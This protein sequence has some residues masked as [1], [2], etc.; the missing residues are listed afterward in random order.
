MAVAQ[1]IKQEVSYSNDRTD[2]TS[3]GEC[4]NFKVRVK[5]ILTK[6][7]NHMNVISSSQCENWENLLH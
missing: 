6:V 5:P 2:E 4:Q 1:T 3:S 7:H